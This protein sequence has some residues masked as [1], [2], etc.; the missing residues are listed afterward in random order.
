MEK[1]VNIQIR[2]NEE[3]RDH[4]FE[5]IKAMGLDMS[6]TINLLI[7][8]IILTKKIP[9]EFPENNKDNN[10]SRKN[11][12]INIRANKEERILVNQIVNDLG[13]DFSTLVNLLMKQIITTEKIPFEISLHNKN[14]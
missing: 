10:V 2:I 4:S 13:F 9:F 14:N 7:K 11:T 5:I 12:L 8:Q 1:N 3:I 6:T